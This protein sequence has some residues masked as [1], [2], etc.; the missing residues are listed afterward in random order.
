MDV[1]IINC[2]SCGSEGRF[3]QGE[4]DLG[5]CPWC[6]GTCI[7]FVDVEPIEMEDLDAMEAPQTE[8]E[9]AKIPDR[10]GD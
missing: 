6:G 4:I 1:R 2:Q 3:Y 9:L 7:E 8:V 5:P 10:R